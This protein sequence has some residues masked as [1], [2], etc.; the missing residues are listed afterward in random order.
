MRV[1]QSKKYDWFELIQYR[2]DTSPFH[3]SDKETRANQ[4]WHQ[5]K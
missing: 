5:R 3:T 1:I 4:A 2:A